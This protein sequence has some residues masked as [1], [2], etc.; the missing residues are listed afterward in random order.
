MKRLETTNKIDH[1]LKEHRNIK[2]ILAVKDNKHK[3]FIIG[4]ADASGKVHHKKQSIAD[5]FA[6]FYGQR[7]EMTDKDEKGENDEK[8]TNE[9]REG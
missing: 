7:Y 2:S 8:D 5:I 6:L 9:G 3:N 1:I 4:M